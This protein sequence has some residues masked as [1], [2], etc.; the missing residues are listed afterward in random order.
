MRP[1]Q[2]LAPQQRLRDLKLV[3]DAGDWSVAQFLWLHQDGDWRHR[4]GMRWNG[5]NHDPGDPQV[6]GE[7]TWFLLPENIIA[8]FV[9]MYAWRRRRREPI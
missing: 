3:Y 1:D 8:D 2:V 5:P 7:A 9:L 6:N 4:V